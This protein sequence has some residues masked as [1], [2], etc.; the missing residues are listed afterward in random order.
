MND[1]LHE[2]ALRIDGPLFRRQRAALLGVL[3]LKVAKDTHE[4]LMGLVELLDE[5]SDQ[6]HDRHNIDCLLEEVPTNL[7]AVAKPSM[8]EAS[9]ADRAA[10]PPAKE[11]AAKISPTAPTAKRAKPGRASASTPR[12]R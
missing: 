8:I 10:Q 2:Y 3:D 1:I 9:A 12:R 4:L 7:V 11:A 5:V 6:A